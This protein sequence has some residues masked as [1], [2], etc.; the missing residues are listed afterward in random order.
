VPHKPPPWTLT[1]S[2]QNTEA[3]GRWYTDPELVVTVIEQERGPDGR[4]A[5]SVDLRFD[6]DGPYVTGI[7][8]RRHHMAGYRG[9]RTNVAPRDVQRLPLAKMVSAALAFASTSEKPPPTQFLRPDEIA[10][11][12][13]SRP[14]DPRVEVEMTY[15]LG[16]EPPEERWFPEAQPLVDARK[17]LL[18]RGR[19]QRGRS[20]DF[21]R[22]L[23]KSY[24]NLELAGLSPVKEIARR[25]RVSENTVHQWV[26]RMRHELGFLEPSPRSKQKEKDDAS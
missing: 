16:A 23:A 7:A 11:G 9:E 22:E 19:P 2:W 25:K 17:I 13:T 26:H 10:A 18:P 24:R 3:Q 12:W 4:L 8:V 14:F 6:E 21:Y 5:V 15:Y 1:A 20:V